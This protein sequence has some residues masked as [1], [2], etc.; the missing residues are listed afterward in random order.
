[1]GRPRLLDEDRDREHSL[2]WTIHDAVDKYDDLPWWLDQI[3]EIVNDDQ[4]E[5]LVVLLLT[6]ASES[7]ISACLSLL[8][9][10][11]DSWSPHRLIAVYDVLRWVGIR[12]PRLNTAKIDL[13]GCCASMRAL[14][15]VRSRMDQRAR[16]LDEASTGLLDARFK[17][18][19]SETIVQALQTRMRHTGRW[20]G[21]REIAERYARS[22]QVSTMTAGVVNPYD[23][24]RKELED[25]IIQE[26]I[27]NPTRYPSALVRMADSDGSRRLAR[28]A[29]PI[30]ITAVQDAWFDQPQPF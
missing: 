26:I 22:W 7:T 20:M 19:V 1:M 25:P 28:R 17:N 2:T 10:R 4:A 3:G 16:V 11:V 29:V 14:V 23:Y 9:E 13:A 27:E 5:F 18:Q 21:S 15:G 30:A 24:E 6:F 8:S 12:R